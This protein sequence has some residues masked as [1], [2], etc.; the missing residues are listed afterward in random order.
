[1]AWH[2]C[3]LR[4]S[5]GSNKSTRYDGSIWRLGGEIYF[6]AYSHLDGWQNS[7]SCGYKTEILVLLLPVC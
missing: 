4:V 2:G 5:K 6:L 1:M 3:L 7:V